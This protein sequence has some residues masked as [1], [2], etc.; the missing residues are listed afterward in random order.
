MFFSKISEIF[1]VAG[2]SGCSIFVL[3]EAEFA[4]LTKPSKDVLVLQPE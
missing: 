3:P 1:E 4:G 2:R